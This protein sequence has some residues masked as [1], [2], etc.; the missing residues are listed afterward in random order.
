MSSFFRF[1][2]ELCFWTLAAGVVIG[3]CV[4]AVVAGAAPV[5]AI[6]IPAAVMI[7]ILA[8]MTAIT[9]SAIRRRRF[10][11][12]MVYLEQA[13]R[14]NLPLSRMMR[15]ASHGERGVIAMRLS[16]LRHDLD[17]GLTVT[18]AVESALPEAPAR[19][20]VTLAAAEHIG[21]LKPALSRLVRQQRSTDDTLDP[22][23][24]PFAR[25]YPVV[26]VCAIGAI[27]MVF[28]IFVMPKYEQLFRDFQVTLPAITRGVIDALRVAGPVVMLLGGVGLL[29]LTGRY[30]FETARP[31][32]IGLTS[33][34]IADR[35]AWSLPIAH[36]LALNRSMADVCAFLTD[37]IAAGIP[38]DR[39]LTEASRLPINAVMQSRM[40]E[41]ADLVSEGVPF[42]E[43]ARKAL[44][45]KLAATLLATVR[46]TDDTAEVFRFL[47]RHYR[48]RFS[49]ADYLLRAMVI[50]LTVLILGVAVAFIALAMFL[51]LLSLMNALSSQALRF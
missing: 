1:I 20:I 30:L 12:V 9:F 44:L 16:D 50:P 32:G 42:A 26:L 34:G 17:Q 29:V 5:A 49:R 14:L 6:A 43:A 15:A 35:V 37:A 7:V 33:L 24:R 36:S 2:L 18:E 11:T 46:S 10:R 4:V 23:Q 31:F 3:I 13:I 41:W 47:E 8:P 27:G 40:L 21:Q 19:A 45:P 51:P 28:A 39:A 22:T 25:L 48:W 38:L